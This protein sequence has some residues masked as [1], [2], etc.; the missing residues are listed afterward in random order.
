M[1][2]TRRRKKGQKS[3]LLEQ[4]ILALRLAGF[5]VYS[6]PLFQKTVAAGTVGPRYAITGWPHPSLYGTR[7]TKEA[8]LVAEGSANG[9]VADADG[10]VRV[11]VEAKWQESPG[12]VD[13]KLPYVYEAFLTSDVP[14][15][16]AL[17][18]GAVWKVGRGKAAFDWLA[19]RPAVVGRTWHVVDYDGFLEFVN[20]AWPR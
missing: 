12:S 2:P 6:H 18:E 4:S 20:G 11:V 13:E 16:V 19:A 15:W 14:N 1:T 17:L 8:L 10:L 3:R 5:E 7:G 9:L